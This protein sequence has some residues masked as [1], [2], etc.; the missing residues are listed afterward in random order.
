VQ[1]P[2]KR[3]ASDV[4]AT[5]IGKTE[6]TLSPAR[7]GARTPEI[8][9]TRRGARALEVTRAEAPVVCHPHPPDRADRKLAVD[10][11]FTDFAVRRTLEVCH[12]P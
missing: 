5:T 2:M 6:L 10:V 11:V 1:P 12:A 8:M 7:S 9:K 4:V 3:D